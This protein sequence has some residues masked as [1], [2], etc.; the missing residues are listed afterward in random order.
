M[1]LLLGLFVSVF[2]LTA[3]GS[4]DDDE[5]GGSFSHPIVGTWDRDNRNGDTQITFKAN[6]TA[7]MTDY[8]DK[9]DYVTTLTGNYKI[10]GNKFI[11]RWTKGTAL[12][13]TIDLDV[14]E[15]GL[16]EIDGNKMI[17]TADNGD[18]IVWT[19]K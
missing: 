7:T 17:T 8:D 19:R 9:E 2:A 6:M 4:D 10:E 14:T 5:G 18:R 13:V 15:S 16:F 3:C 11:I 12:N 1:S